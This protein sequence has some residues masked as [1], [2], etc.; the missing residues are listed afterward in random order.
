MQR[1]K[2][3]RLSPKTQGPRTRPGKVRLY[4]TTN[5][6]GET[7]VCFEEENRAQPTQTR[8]RSHLR[9]MVASKRTQR[10]QIN[11][12]TSASGR[13]R[14][15]HLVLLNCFVSAWARGGVHFELQP[16]RCFLSYEGWMSTKN[17]TG[18]FCSECPICFSLSELPQNPETPDKLKHIGHEGEGD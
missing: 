6:P 17:C 12:H 4:L 2:H 5:V 3:V 1:H 8:E 15:H 16:L 10:V 11:G 13:I 9:L 7:T 18:P 14:F